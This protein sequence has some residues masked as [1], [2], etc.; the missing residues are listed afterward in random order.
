MISVI[1]ISKE[2]L[3][4]LLRT[5][6]SLK[7]LFACARDLEWILID[8]ASA[9]AQA[10]GKQKATNLLKD[11]THF[12]SEPDE[13][14]YEAMNKGIALAS[15]PYLW[16]LNSGDMAGPAFEYAELLEILRT[17][18]PD[19]V[20]A[21]YEQLYRGVWTRRKAKRP[22]SVWWGMPTSHQSML[23]R[24]KQLADS[25]YR[26]DFKLAGDYELVCRLTVRMAVR[27]KYFPQLARFNPVISLG[28]RALQRF[29]A[30]ARLAKIAGN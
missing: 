7:P 8:G 24:R 1:T 21:D 3:D 6:E 30:G 19:L 10:A 29:Q 15:N 23:F 13:G 26:T 28:K 9:W 11:A 5:H 2:D 14:I 4:G 16:F 17:K 22:G 27:R 20:F 25:P 12:V 18:E